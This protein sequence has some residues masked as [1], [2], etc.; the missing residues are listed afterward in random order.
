M[1][2]LAIDPGP[3]QSAYV[4]WDTQEHNFISYCFKKMGLVSNKELR[5]LLDDVYLP[6]DLIAIEVPQS[7]GRVIGRSMFETC[8]EVGR[9][10]QAAFHKADKIKLYGRPT[11]KGQIGGRTDAEIR[12]SL[13]IRYGEARKGEKLEGVV[14]DIWSALALAVALEENPKLKEW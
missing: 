12:A 1:R 11:I 6:V 3:E 13:R 5:C 10:I 4:L 2:I 7:Y 8:I 9:F 14:R